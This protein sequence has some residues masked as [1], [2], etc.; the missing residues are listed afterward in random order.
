V[1]KT[2]NLRSLCLFGHLC[3]Q[4]HKTVGGH[5]KEIK[6]VKY[7]KR[8]L[9]YIAC[10]LF[11]ETIIHCQISTLPL[12]DSWQE[13]FVSS[14]TGLTEERD[15]AECGVLLKHCLR[16]CKHGLESWAEWDPGPSVLACC[17]NLP[18]DHFYIEKLFISRFTIACEWKSP[19]H[20]LNQ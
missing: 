16:C 14:C 12:T 3:L 9:K 8:C 11:T 2:S 6:C 13:S 7:L 18:R 1:F 10:S 15:L 4:V 20:K 5:L 19:P 17:F